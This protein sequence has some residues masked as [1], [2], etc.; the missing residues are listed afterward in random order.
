MVGKLQPLLYPL[1]SAYPP[2]LGDPPWAMAT[3]QGPSLRNL[4]Q[5]LMMPD[6]KLRATLTEA[7]VAMWTTNEGSVPLDPT[8]SPRMR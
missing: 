7:M 6:P 1:A 5:R 8:M 4:L 2:E 3:R